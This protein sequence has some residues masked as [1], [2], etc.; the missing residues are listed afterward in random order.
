MT[1][2]GLLFTI[3]SIWL[4]SINMKPML[5]C[6]YLHNSP[7]CS[8]KIRRDKV[9]VNLVGNSIGYIS[10]RAGI[11][12][13]HP[14]R[15]QK[16]QSRVQIIYFLE[17]SR[18]TFCFCQ[19]L[20]YLIIIGIWEQRNFLCLKIINLVYCKLCESFLKQPSSWQFKLSCVCDM[21]S[22]YTYDLRMTRGNTEIEY[23]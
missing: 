6:I 4:I 18:K 17:H 16:E 23:W 5:K 20:C 11:W 9:N 8:G 19:I 3:K 22:L 13:T 21:Y 12:R 15:N 14:F 10:P 1:M 2:S 7:L